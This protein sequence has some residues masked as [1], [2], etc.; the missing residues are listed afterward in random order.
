MSQAAGPPCA[1]WPERPPTAW[2][3]TR[4]GAWGWAPAYPCLICMCCPPT[5]RRCGK[6]RTTLAATQPRPGMWRATKPISSCAMSPAAPS[7]PCAS[8]RGRHMPALILR[9]TAAWAWARRALLPRCT[10]G[11]R[12]AAEPC[13]WT[14]PAPPP[15]RGP[16]RTLKPDITPAPIHAVLGEVLTLPLYAWRYLSDLN[17]S[18][19]L[20][21]M[22]EDV[23]QRF[24]VGASPRTLAP[25]DV[26]GLAAATVQALHQKLAAKDAE[27]MALAERLSALEQQLARKNGGAR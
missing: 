7:F 17:A 26:A 1:G 19:H 6:S 14:T 13:W 22:A 15:A 3:W 23:H 24:Q 25:S 5:P 10:C 27:L 18:L 12:T 21:P 9:A 16:S 8:G 20:G 4:K 11:A 2:L